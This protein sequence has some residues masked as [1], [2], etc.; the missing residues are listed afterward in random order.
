[1]G[2]I[3]RR[4]TWGVIDLDTRS[5]HIFVQEEWRY[6]WQI[7]PGAQPWTLRER[8]RFHDTVDRHV[9]GTWSRRL[10]VRPTGTH[11][12]A[13][14]TRDLPVE[15]D[16]RW[17]LSGGHWTVNVKKLAPGTPSPRS[18]VDFG[19]RRIQL[20]HLDGIP[21]AVGNAA[22]QSRN[23]F[24]TIPHEFGH[25]LPTAAG[26]ALPVDDEYGAGH[27][28]LADTDSLM[29]IGRQVRSR[30][31]QVVLDELNAMLPDLQFTM[32]P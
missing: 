10:Q 30:H 18:W 14:P 11:P 24:Y 19:A 2:H 21:H 4:A 28:H 3:V 12:L 26:S 5:G 27:A 32:A 1:M 7:D 22:N 31:I 25:T 6:V 15:F 13:N 17:V 29:N 9:W 20:D 16:V 23:R 8:R